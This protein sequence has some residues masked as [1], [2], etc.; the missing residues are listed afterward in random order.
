M[1]GGAAFLHPLPLAEPLPL[2]VL[3]PLVQAASP[4]PAAAAAA[5]AVSLLNVLTRNLPFSGLVSSGML[6]EPPGVAP[7]RTGGL[8]I[9]KFLRF[10]YSPDSPRLS[11]LL[12]SGARPAPVV[13]LPSA[14]GRCVNI[15]RAKLEFAV[16]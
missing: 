3:L 4:S 16:N 10:R 2:L 12:R 9:W 7:G 13:S 11:R 14:H 1:F 15:A 5:T 6:N 8:R